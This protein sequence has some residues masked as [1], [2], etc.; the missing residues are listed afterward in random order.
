MELIN[1]YQIQ[2]IRINKIFSVSVQWFIS[3]SRKT[4]FSSD[5]RKPYLYL[6]EEVEKLSFHQT[7]SKT[8]GIEYSPEHICA[9]ISEN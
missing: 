2:W 8:P 5:N 4:F 1:R 3:D 9:A 7:C 6:L